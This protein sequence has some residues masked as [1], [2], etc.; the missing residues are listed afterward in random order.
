ML[1][2]ALNMNN[3]DDE[4]IE[5]FGDEWKKFDYLVVDKEK[6]KNNFD[7]YFKIFPWHLL[8]S[9]AAGFDMGCGSGRW[10]Q[11]VAPR[12]GL[13]NCIEPSKAILVAERNLASYK[14]IK[15]YQETTENCSVINGSQ[16]FGYCLGVLHHIPNT[17]EALNDCTKLLKKGAPILLYLYYN[18]ENKPGWYRSIW[19]ISN[20]LRKAI[21]SAPKPV[22]NF[23]CASIAVTIYFPLS[24]SAK[25][26]EWLGFNVENIPLSDYR[27]KP[28]Y[29]LSN[30]ALDRF[31]TRLE[32][33]FSKTSITDMLIKAGCERI[34]FSNARPFWCCV[35]IKK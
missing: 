9:D 11:F 21:S 33:R 1:I 35:A 19:K 17:Q 32:Q 16:D 14:N 3:K 27:N 2:K 7:E 23:F 24:R 15:F 13:L 29:Q 10:A 20:I 12:V 4:V 6:L 8:S 22:K 30:D 34:E 26:F 28:F 18:F 31:G 5:D 25:M